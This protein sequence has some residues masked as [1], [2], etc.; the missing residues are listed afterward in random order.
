MR[1]CD[2]F[3]QQKP[4]GK[5]NGENNEEGPNVRADGNNAQ[6][7]QLLFKYEIIKY[8]IKKDIERCICATT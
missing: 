3:R 6:M 7:D 2:V 5:G 8:K 1:K 4:G